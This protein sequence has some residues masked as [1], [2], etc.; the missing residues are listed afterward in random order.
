MGNY[1][2]GPM[3]GYIM[4]GTIQ[5]GNTKTLYKGTYIWCVCVLGR[6]SFDIIYLAYK[7]NG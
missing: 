6:K 3:I 2:I 5:I 7:R 1:R 4:L